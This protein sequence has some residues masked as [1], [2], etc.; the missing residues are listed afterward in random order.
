M[1]DKDKAE[2]ATPL[3]DEIKDKSE[4]RTSQFPS[5]NGQEGVEVAERTADSDKETATVFSKVFVVPRE[6]YENGT[7]DPDAV[8]QRNM[9]AVRQF[10]VSQGLRPS[11]DVKFVGEE[12]Y[13]AD[14]TGRSVALRYE[15]PAVPAAVA[16]AFEVAHVTIPHDGPNAR[17]NK[18][19]V[20]SHEDRVAASHAIRRVGTPEENENDRAKI[21]KA[22]GKK[23]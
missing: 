5:L 13:P 4:A 12:D 10:M 3:F 23:S 11:A 6:S 9:T 7:A 20:D 2:E 8:H 22:T 14:T 18:E 19:L 15:V 16:S 21:E 17:A 1:V